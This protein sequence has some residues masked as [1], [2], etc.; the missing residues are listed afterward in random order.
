MGGHMTEVD[1]DKV[2]EGAKAELRQLAADVET[3]KGI[4]AEADRKVIELEKKASSVKKLL[5]LKP[6]E[7]ELLEILFFHTGS[8]DVP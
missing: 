4:R 2:M 3:A 8:P 1:W 7:R 5:K 6:F